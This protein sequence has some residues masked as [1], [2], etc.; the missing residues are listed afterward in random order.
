M[1]Q[2]RLRTI[3]IATGATIAL[4]GTG[5]AYAAVA[6]PIDSSGVIHG[7]Y[8]T[9]ATANSHAVVLDDAG[10]ACPSGYTAIKWN[11]KG[12]TGPT[13][14]QAPAGPAGPG[15]TSITAFL[16]GGQSLNIAT[17][18]AFTVNA[19]CEPSGN[20]NA[21]YL[22][23]IPRNGPYDATGWVSTT[24]LN[25]ATPQLISDSLAGGSLQYSAASGSAIDEHVVVLDENST[26]GPVTFDL[27]MFTLPIPVGLSKCEVWGTAIPST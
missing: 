26:P 7:C 16:Q 11:Q 13:G 21:I 17:V 15:A 10:T 9:T 12:P 25:G 19:L 14:P 22:T 20:P 5:T 24:G 23:L 2:P 3:M 4:I 8:K 1:R 27:Q 18:G 6:G